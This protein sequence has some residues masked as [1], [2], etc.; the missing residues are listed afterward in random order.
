MTAA[1]APGDPGRPSYQP[2]TEHA[3][4]FRPRLAGRWATCSLSAGGWRHRC[5]LSTTNSKPLC[6]GSVLWE[7][8]PAEP[9]CPDTLFICL[10]KKLL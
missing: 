3:I 6:E 1:T 7:M 5:R 10:L 8:P 4:C 9:L 2:G